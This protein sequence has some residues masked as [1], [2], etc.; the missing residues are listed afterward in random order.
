ML[1][2][3]EVSGEITVATDAELTLKNVVF[4]AGVCVFTE[5]GG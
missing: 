1:E 3:V 5:A 4:A 2:G